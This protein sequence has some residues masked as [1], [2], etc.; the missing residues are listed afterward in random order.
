MHSS[1]V[2]HLPSGTFVDLALPRRI[3]FHRS[4]G[5]L[6]AVTGVSTSFHDIAQMVAEKFT[7]RAVVKSL[8][9]AGRAVWST[10]GI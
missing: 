2:L 8:P 10:M 9:H 3:L 4:S 7:P 6:N 5:V 1:F